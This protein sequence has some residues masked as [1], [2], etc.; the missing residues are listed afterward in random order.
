MSWFSKSYD[1][2]HERIA[3]ENGG[4]LSINDCQA[5]SIWFQERRVVGEPYW[6]END[7]CF[8]EVEQV[9]Y[10]FYCTGCG[11]E[12]CLQKAERTGKIKKMKNM[13]Q[14]EVREMSRTVNCGSLVNPQ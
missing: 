4:H 2:A 6:C 12:K 14:E 7:A 10:H 8:T 1:C 11:K 9:T 5:S 13:S 3:D